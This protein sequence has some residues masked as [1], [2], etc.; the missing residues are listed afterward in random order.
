MREYL[1][2]R[3]A[4]L[5]VTRLAKWKTGFQMTAI[6]FLLAGDG[7]GALLGIPWLPVAL[8]GAIL[9]WIAGVLTMITGWDYLTKG[10][11]HVDL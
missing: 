11:Q 9:L 4:S 8:I 5:P 6:G 7:T 2:E 10:L 3:R 1:A